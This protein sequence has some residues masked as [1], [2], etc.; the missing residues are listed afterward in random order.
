[1]QKIMVEAKRTK[2]LT[3]VDG[4]I[5]SELTNSSSFKKSKQMSQV[6]LSVKLVEG[7]NKQK[8]PEI[9]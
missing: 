2:L 4:V 8:V 6:M 3:C 7:R 9:S 5:G 1:M